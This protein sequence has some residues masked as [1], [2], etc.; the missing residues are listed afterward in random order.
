MRFQPFQFRVEYLTGRLVPDRKEWRPGR[1]IRRTRKQFRSRS[2]KSTCSSDCRWQRTEHGRWLQYRLT[3]NGHRQ[4]FFDAVGRYV[5]AV[6]QMILKIS[7]RSNDRL[8]FNDS[9]WVIQT[10]TVEMLVTKLLALHFDVTGRLR[11]T[12]MAL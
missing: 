1:V 12:H 8:F 5:A 2:D 7:G 4:T 11:Y 6:N 3:G 9:D 10:A